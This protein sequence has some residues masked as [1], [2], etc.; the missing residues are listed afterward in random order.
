LS[1]QR[2]VEPLTPELA[3]VDPD[4]DVEL[5]TRSTHLWV[6]R[7]SRRSSGTQWVAC[8]RST[9]SLTPRTAKAR[10]EEAF[11]AKTTNVSEGLRKGIDKRTET[12]RLSEQSADETRASATRSAHAERQA[13]VR[14]QAPRTRAAR[15]SDGQPS[16]RTS[17]SASARSMQRTL[18]LS[19]NSTTRTRAAA[20]L[21]DEAI[22]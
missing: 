17:R 5:A 8:T 1:N 3:L 4:D 11:T 15:C 19:P 16:A 20:Q 6:S 18:S 10:I 14:T 9:G 7:R 21:P 2:V 12:Q 13:T 22:R